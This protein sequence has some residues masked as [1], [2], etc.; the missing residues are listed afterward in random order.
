MQ[1]LNNKIFWS[2]Y[3]KLW[4]EPGEDDDRRKIKGKRSHERTLARWIN[5]IK[6][7]I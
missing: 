4:I 1:T 6:G 3:E 2:Y 5:K 7:Y